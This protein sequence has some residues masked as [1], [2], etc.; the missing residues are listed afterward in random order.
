VGRTADAIAEGEAIALSAARLQLKNRILISTIAGNENFDADSFIS[1][2]REVIEQLAAES[3]KA[4]E[5]LRRLRKRAWGRHTQS[6]GTH[7]YRDKDVRNL[8][9]RSKQ[10]AGVAKRLRE[11]IEHPDRLRELIE[12]ARDAAWGD[13]S[14]NIDTRLNIEA[15]RPDEDPDYERMREA[16]MQA[17]RMVDLQ[18]LASQTRAR[19]KALGKVEKAKAKGRK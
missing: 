2:A 11:L 4:D 8:R 12:R 9:K 10:S 19:E 14:S 17:L 18:S 7:D 5:D 3:E 1:D 6:H 13:V 15:M 16:R